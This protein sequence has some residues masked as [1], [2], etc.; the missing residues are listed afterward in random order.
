MRLQRCPAYK[1]L[2]LATIAILLKLNEI[3]QPFIFL[4]FE[5]KVMHLQMWFLSVATRT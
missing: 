4:Q 1:A 5:D 2:S 3:S